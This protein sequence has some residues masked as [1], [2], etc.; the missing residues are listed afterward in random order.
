MSPCISTIP[1]QAPFHH[2]YSTARARHLR[3]YSPAAACLPSPPRFPLAD[4][5][6][7]QHLH[8]S[9]FPLHFPH[10]RPFSTD[11]PKGFHSKS[12]GTL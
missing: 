10:R 3:V 9:A 1:C 6:Y 11:L 5:T 2:T 7:T 4:V 8:P 12:L